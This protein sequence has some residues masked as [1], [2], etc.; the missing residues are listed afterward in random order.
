MASV[1]V[2]WSSIKLLIQSSVNSDC[3]FWDKLHWDPKAV[4]YL[5]KEEGGHGLLHLQSRTAAFQLQFVQRLLSGP[6]DLYWRS[7]AFM[8]LQSFGSLGMDRSLFW[9]NPKKMDLSKLPIFY[10]NVLKVWT[11]FTVQRPCRISS[12]YWL[13]QEPLVCGS[14][15]DITLEGPFPAL[16]GIL[17]SS[18][19]YYHLK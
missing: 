12:L 4:L 11:M 15:M 7:I 3:F 19:F 14:R 17:L 6:A 1:N 2:C 9:L 13:L 10:R 8:V 5:P 18:I 16:N